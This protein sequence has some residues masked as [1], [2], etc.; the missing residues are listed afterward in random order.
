MTRSC[1]IVLRLQSSLF[2]FGRFAAKIPFRRGKFQSDVAAVV[3]A[4]LRQGERH[5]EQGGCLKHRTRAARGFWQANNETTSTAVHLLLALAPQ[6]PFQ[7]FL[8]DAN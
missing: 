2:R 3:L 5:Q 8:A 6:W 7:S 4:I 1:P